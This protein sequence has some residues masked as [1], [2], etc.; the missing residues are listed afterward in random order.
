M[1][2]ISKWVIAQMTAVFGICDIL[3]RIRIIG[4][5][6]VITVPYPVPDTDPAI[7]VIDLQDAKKKFSKFLCLLLFVGTFTSL[8][9][10]F[11]S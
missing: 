8:F 2:T 3:V 5:I 11:K 1:P 7:F 4:S 9:K 6:L 10:D